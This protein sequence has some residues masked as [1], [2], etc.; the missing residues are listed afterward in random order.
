MKF[1][2]LFRSSWLRRS[3]KLL[4][5]LL[6]LW[7]L[8]WLI[9]PPVLQN[10]LE[11]RL[12]ARLAREVSIGAV[13]FKPWSLELTIRDLVIAQAEQRRPQLAIKRIYID[14]EAQSLLRLAP[15]IDALEVDAPEL[16]LRHL[17]G[18][19][20]DIDDLLARL[21]PPANASASDPLRFALYNLV[22]TNG[23][24]TL[25]DAP[26]GKLHQLSDL[27]I[28]LPFLSNLASHRQVQVQPQLAFKLNGSAFDS[29]AVAQ[30]FADVQKSV[31]HFSLKGFDLAPYLGYWPA[32]LPL[33]L[34]AAVLDADLK[35]VF[36]QTTSTTLKL[37]GQVSA[38]RVR[39]MA[40]GPRSS[41]EVLAFEKL[42]VQ[43]TDARPL[44]R[45][46]QLGQIELL[47]PVVQVQRDAHGVLNWQRLLTSPKPTENAITS[48]SASA[49]AASATGKKDPESSD[50]TLD[51]AQFTLQ[52][53]EL[54]WRDHS[55]S[56]PA[57]LDL[58]ALDV[59]AS[60]LHWPLTRS[61]PFEGHTQLDRAA[62]SFKG[63][64]SERA[65]ELSAQLSAAPLSL[66]APYLADR[67]RPSLNGVL[68][69]DLLLNWA[70]ARSA[71][72]PMQ[73]VLR[74]PRLTLDQLELADA[75]VKPTKTSKAQRLAS[76]QQLQL[77]DAALDLGS[78]SVQLGT[79]QIRQAKTALARQTD[80][81]WMFEDWLKAPAASASASASTTPPAASPAAQPSAAPDRPWVV[82]LKQLDL[83]QSELSFADA[84]PAQPVALVLDGLTLQLKD[85]SSAGTQAFAWKV[86]TR[87]RHGE[88]EPGQLGGQGSAQLNPLA[89]QAQLSM[90]RLPLL[91]L[92]PYAG[93]ALNLQLLH[94]AASFNGRADI[95]SAAP[96]ITAKVQGD[97]QLEDLRADTLAR[98]EQAAEE[99]LSWRELQL[100]GLDLTVSPGLAPRITVMQTALRDFFAKLTLSETGR[101][102]LQEVR[103]NT[104]DKSKEVAAISNSTSATSQNASDSSSTPLVQFGALTLVNGRVDFTDRFIKPNYSA[105][106]TDLSGTLG[107]FSSQPV[108]GEVQ[109]ADLLLRG[110][111][112]GTATLEIT[113]K[114]NPL[115]K[116]LALD[117]T[118]RVRDL[119]LAPLSPYAAR[120][121][122]YGIE[123]GKLSVDVGY[124]V[125]PD[126]QLSADHN[127]LLNQ[128]KFGDAVPGAE[129]S[130]PVKLAVALLAD[131]QGVIDINLP[132][133]GS[134]NDPQF[135]LAPLI[136]K[137]LGNLLMKAITAPFSLLASALGGAGGDEL[138][139]VAFEPG[140]A[141]LGPE[142]MA[143]LDK[144][145]KA[146]QARPAL[147]MTVT[148]TASLQLEADAFAANSSTPCCWRRSARCNPK[149]MPAPPW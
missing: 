53:G 103:S 124:K 95:S 72:S 106:L 83:T 111:A 70:A 84:V 127:I 45:Q 49:A 87:L 86:A 149:A 146:L 21:K 99:L 68:T 104:H 76:I 91:A 57:Q 78:Q 137:V 35:L 120:Y 28:R 34:G 96:G 75:T 22:L 7:T 32:S 144:V 1:V 51:L 81:R 110:R 56:Q 145:A 8:A 115:A 109:L 4:A 142:A 147:K 50:W 90:K 101:L 44:E 138:S 26:Q 38:S 117:I 98:A 12:G 121:A 33:R 126:G 9:V 67:I 31:T 114:V 54:R 93:D 43:V 47:R 17:G 13:D 18:G 85:F 133:S 129:N 89:A 135:R 40:P 39:L 94:G 73:W 130:L 143:Q 71:Q 82:S 20:Y 105:R 42:S 74:L 113:G 88:D 27:T 25:D 131:S 23:A 66:A 48:I 97:V 118:G 60:A 10:Q 141:A 92:A 79:V 2:D 59:S 19:R 107:G 58:H 102:N 52:G 80:G 132:V 11:T 63:Q 108:N 16:Y 46:L 36:E 62:L 24:M 148:G 119:E 112:E 134:I 14:V 136:F 6:V 125:Q 30:P 3:L 37:S 65:A 29:G 122:G 69:L 100:S 128:L 5:G 64:A 139:M 116:P 41:D 123:R 140:S 15:V 55:T 77:T 61:V